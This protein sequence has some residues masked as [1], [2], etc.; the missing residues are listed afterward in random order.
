MGGHKATVA[1][2]TDG[3]S[4]LS[5]WVDDQFVPIVEADG[6]E[7]RGG[8]VIFP[9]ALDNTV[10]FDFDLAL[11]ASGRSTYVGRITDLDIVDR[12]ADLAGAT[13]PEE[14]PDHV[15]KPSRRA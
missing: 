13:D 3:P 6:F 15:G 4:R 9:G 10:V 11:S 2:F 8:Y 14:N 1:V 5:L 12:I 7:T